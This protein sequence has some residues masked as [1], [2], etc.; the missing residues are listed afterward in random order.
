MIR[1]KVRAQ[2]KQELMRSSGLADSA[3]ENVW[4]GGPAGAAV[5]P[6]CAWVVVC[7]SWRASCNPIDQASNEN[8][9]ADDSI[10]GEECS[11]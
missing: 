5:G 4:D 1:R 11:V 7:D 8:D 2:M 9:D 6:S 3:W 10:G